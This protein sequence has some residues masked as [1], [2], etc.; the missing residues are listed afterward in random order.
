[1]RNS[2]VILVVVGVALNTFGLG[3]GVADGWD[4]QMTLNAVGLTFSLSAV[5]LE[6][7]RVNE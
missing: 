7:F 3:V 4:W 2:L 1:M 5:V 6:C